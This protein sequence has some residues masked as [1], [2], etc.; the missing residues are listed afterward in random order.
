MNKLH[1]YTINKQCYFEIHDISTFDPSFTKGCAKGIR[2]IVAKRKIPKDAHLFYNT[3]KKVICDEK[4]NRAKLLIS[5]QWLIDNVLSFRKLFENKKAKKEDEDAEGNETDEDEEEQNDED[6]SDD[7]KPEKLPELLE[8]GEEEM[9]H[10]A[11]GN[12]IEIEVRGERDPKKCF[13]SVDDIAKGFNLP[14]LTRVLIKPDSG[15]VIEQHYKIYLIFVTNSNKV[16]IEKRKYYLTYKGLIRMLYVS[17][18]KNADAFQEWATEILF[19]HQMGEKEQKIVL[20]SKL[21]GAPVE[22]VKCVFKAN[23]TSTPCIYLFRIGTVKQLR[24]KLHI[25]NDF[26]DDMI[27]C[28]YGF[29]DDLERRTSEHAK[30]FGKLTGHSIELV[31]YAHI[32]PKFLSQAETHIKKLV[33]YTKCE[34]EF[35]KFKELICIS[36]KQLKKDFAEEYSNIRQLF[37][38]CVTE[39]VNQ[40]ESLKKDIEITQ[41]KHE[42]VLLK[43]ENEINQLKHENALLKRKTK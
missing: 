4:Y 31:M 17:R 2:T 6:E 23:V 8:L 24:K 12:V 3:T 25:S 14:N 27:V 30:N 37:G 32:D 33:G 19:T 5:K 22:S 15:Y 11:D 18:S 1:A 21:L 35:D 13:F 26:D 28:K 29:T 34:I 16:K 43:K 40:I 9:F 42:N 10:D 36:N 7:T 39:L 20:A 41:L 38:G